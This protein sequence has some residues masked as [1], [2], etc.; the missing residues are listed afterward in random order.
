MEI[1][2]RYRLYLSPVLLLEDQSGGS[3]QKEPSNRRT[4]G[5]QKW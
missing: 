5:L 1:G 4:G 2:K 3:D